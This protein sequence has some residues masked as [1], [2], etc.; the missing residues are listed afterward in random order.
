MIEFATVLI[1]SRSRLVAMNDSLGVLHG[2]KKHLQG[3]QLFLRS[4]INSVATGEDFNDKENGETA[5]QAQV[6]KQTQRKCYYNP[7]N[8]DYAALVLF[9]L[10]YIMFNCYYIFLYI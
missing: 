7:D 9:L 2:N 4:I 8:I 10:S 6:V 1:I 3:T 5:R